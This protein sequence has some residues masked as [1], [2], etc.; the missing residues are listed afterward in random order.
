MCTH[1]RARGSG[2]QKVK[3][4]PA[5]TSR[6]E[7]KQGQARV[8]LARAIYSSAQILLLDDVSLLM[9]PKDHNA[10]MHSSKVFA[11]L[12]VH[13]SQWIVNNCFRGKLVAGRTIIMAVCRKSFSVLHPK[14]M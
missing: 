6:N 9:A 12:D 7:L 4:Y 8:T 3:K 13:T 11:A 2:G 5:V 1:A 10:L 14:S